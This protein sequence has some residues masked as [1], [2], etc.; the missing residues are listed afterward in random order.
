MNDGSDAS[1]C[2]RHQHLKV[3]IL[4]FR[5]ID[6]IWVQFI[7]HGIHTRSHDPVDGKGVDIGAVQLLDD[8]IMY[9][10]PLTKLEALGLRRRQI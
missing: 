1:V 9:F 6:G 2:L 10:G 4:L 7:Q 5:N 3:L 8:R